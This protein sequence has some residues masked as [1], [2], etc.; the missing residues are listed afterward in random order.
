MPRRPGLLLRRR[1]GQRRQ[2][3][4]PPIYADG[5]FPVHQGGG[6]GGSG[7]TQPTADVVFVHGLSGGAFESW[8]QEVVDDKNANYKQFWPGVWFPF[9]FERRTRLPCRVLSVDFNAKPFK[10]AGDS[11]GEPHTLQE[12]AQALLLKLELAQVGRSGGPVVFITHSVGGLLTKE[13]LMQALGQEG[14]PL[15]V[16]EG[17]ENGGPSGGDAGG[18]VRRASDAAVEAARMPPAHAALIAERTRGIVFY[19]VPHRGSPLMDILAQPRDVIKA[20]GLS[21]VAFHPMLKFLT[22]EFRPGLILNERFGH[23]F[24]PRCLSLG[25]GAA[26]TL[27]GLLD[28]DLGGLGV[29]QALEVIQVVERNSSNP[30]YGIYEEVPGIMHSV[31][32]KPLSMQDRRYSAMIEFVAQVCQPDGMQTAEPHPPQK[33]KK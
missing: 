3:L 10:F 23:L 15:E 30:G 25:E 13:M 12:E 22:T 14:A 28:T 6:G 4:L 33:A 11:D 19:S 26:E 7:E 29:G 24:G 9:D 27:Q 16:N 5:I 18:L 8:Q 17:H 1:R 21:S 32:N 31:I 20:T 2:Q